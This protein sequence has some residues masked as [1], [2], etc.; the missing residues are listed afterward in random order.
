MVSDVAPA[1]PQCG[2]PRYLY[3]QPPYYPQQQRAVV[4]K[5]DALHDPNLGCAVAGILIV[6]CAIGVLLMFSR[7][8]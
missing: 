8:C 2:R 4:T 1:C 6:L 3:Q 5:P 7:A